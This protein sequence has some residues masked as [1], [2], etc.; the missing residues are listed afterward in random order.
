MGHEGHDGRGA[1]AIRAPFLPV[2]VH[3]ASAVAGPIDEVG[4]WT[5]DKVEIV[6]AYARAFAKIIESRDYFIPIYID[7]FAGGGLLLSE[8]TGEIVAGTPLRIVDVLPPF[9]EYHFV[10]KD[11]QK[12]A[13]LHELIGDRREVTVHEGDSNEILPKGILPTMTFE[14]YRK[15]LL[16]LDPYRLDV[17]WKVVEAAGK[18]R[19][20]DLL[21]NF[22]IMDMNRNVLFSDPERVA[23][24]QV[25]RMNRFWGDESWRRDC[26]E[27]QPG[28][29]GGIFRSKKPGN[30]AAVRAYQRRLKD[31]AGFTHLSTALDMRN[32][33]GA[34]LYYL[35]GAS[36]A[37]VAVNV[38]NDVFRKRRRERMEQQQR[39]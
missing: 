20:V 36:Q 5:E 13:A 22:P 31:V 8:A 33:S 25:A 19:C 23:P 6:Q 4:P 18:S 16:F 24:D 7:G 14:S 30:E 17:D 39:G 15:G 2:R 37:S 3:C 34:I 29:F 11:R 32:R 9:T 1:G 38:F 10:E 21:L 35:L 27:E 28:L 26:Y 12:I